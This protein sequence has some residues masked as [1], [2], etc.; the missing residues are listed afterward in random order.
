MGK[1]PETMQIKKWM[2]NIDFKRTN[3]WKNHHAKERKGDWKLAKVLHSG[4]SGP[5]SHLRKC[6][7][8]VRE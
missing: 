4:D 3:A 7:G 2:N 1:I 6:N 8:N 5:R